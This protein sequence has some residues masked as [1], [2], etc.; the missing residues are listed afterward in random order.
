MPRTRDCIEHGLRPSF[1]IP[2]ERRG[3]PY[4]RRHQKY[5]R[6]ILEQRWQN[7]CSNGVLPVQGRFN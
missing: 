6:A 7:E 4:I 5:S 2:V 1:S 3:S